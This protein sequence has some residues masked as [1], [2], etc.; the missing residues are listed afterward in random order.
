[1]LAWYQAWPRI[2]TESSGLTPLARK[3]AVLG[4]EA[5]APSAASGAFRPWP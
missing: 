5:K 1:M 2:A 3:A 4:A